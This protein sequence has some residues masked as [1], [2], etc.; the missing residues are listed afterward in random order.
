MSRVLIIGNIN[1]D[2]WIGALLRHV[3]AYNNKIIID[4]FNTQYQ[5]DESG[6][7]ASICNNIICKKKHFPNI[8]YKIPKLRGF[9][10]SKDVTLSLKEWIK[11]CIKCGTHYDIINFQFLKHN[12]IGLWPNL[13]QI[14]SKLVLTPWGSDILRASSSELEKIKNDALHCD[15]I[16]ITENDRFNVQIKQSIGNNNVQYLH[17]DLG[18]EVID[19]LSSRLNISREDSK[20]YLGL[21]GKYIIEI[22]YNGHSAQNHLDVIESIQSI[23]ELLPKN[24]C[25]VLPMTYGLTENYKEEIITRLKLYNL[26]YK[27]YTEYLSIDEIFYLRRSPDIFI[28]AQKSDANS[29]SLA[30]YMICGTTIVNAT[31]LS[32]ANREVYGKP[33]YEFSDFSELSN[34]IL[35]ACENGTLIKSELISDMKKL[36][37]GYWSSQWANLYNGK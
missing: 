33:Y 10:F 20:K 17:L 8:F 14:A 30:E 24:L 34:A 21:S 22:G 25:I 28:H 6:L 5:Y 11:N 19:N 23:R 36:G 31:W 35:L 18:S 13:K 29:A 1:D 9:C 16:T 12:S 27:L 2:K 4:V 7:T 32:Y 15:I 3:K 26:D 37:W